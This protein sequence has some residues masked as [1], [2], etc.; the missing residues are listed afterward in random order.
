MATLPFNFKFKSIAEVYNQSLKGD[1]SSFSSTNPNVGQYA[2]LQEINAA[3]QPTMRELVAGAANAVTNSYGPVGQFVSKIVP[4][5]A[6]QY[7][8]PLVRRFQYIKENQIKLVEFYKSTRGIEFFAKQVLLHKTNQYIS[9]VGVAAGLVGLLPANVPLYGGLINSLTKNYNGQRDFNAQN[10]ITQAALSSLGQ[11]GVSPNFVGLFGSDLDF[12]A[13]R[14]P[15]VDLVLGAYRQPNPTTSLEEKKGIQSILGA[16]LP[17]VDGDPKLYSRYIKDV[18][19]NKADG[20]LELLYNQLIQNPI[21]EAD[22]NLDYDFNKFNH[23]KKDILGLFNRFFNRRYEEH[24]VSKPGSLKLSDKI[25]YGN[26]QFPNNKNFEPEGAMGPK[27]PIVRYKFKFKNPQDILTFQFET[28]R[29]RTLPYTEDDS[30]LQSL[31]TPSDREDGEL[32]YPGIGEAAEGATS[33]DYYFS[34]NKQKISEVGQKY[35]IGDIINTIVTAS[36]DEKAASQNSKDKNKKNY[37]TIQ[38]DLINFSIDFN[39]EDPTFNTKTLQFRALLQSDITD[40]YAASYT[41]SRYIGRADQVHSYDGFTRTIGLSFSIYPRNPEEHPVIMEKLNILAS[42]LTPSYSKKG[43]S[44]STFTTP[45]KPDEVIISD[46]NGDIPRAPIVRLTIGNYI[47][48]QYGY[49]TNMTYNIK[50]SNMWDIYTG[51][52]MVVEIPTFSFVPIHNF[53][54]SQEGKNN[55]NRSKFIHN[56]LPKEGLTDNQYYIDTTQI[57]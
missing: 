52:P 42:L 25:L 13:P 12:N 29:Q 47:K 16:F 27:A 35:H 31:K 11:Q 5:A 26:Y 46:V 23:S 28:E 24:Y 6:E 34:G 33:I 1:Y 18:R 38:D 51:L 36:V 53:V 45:G 14:Q 8:S 21:G 22:F 57:Q 2:R 40:I 43:V 48:K 37:K 19:R 20:R 17:F 9:P 4:A 3:V 49:I 54:V 15:S 50:N 30:Y 44:S 41:N 39:L 32:Y 55:D 7:L 10:F 56:F